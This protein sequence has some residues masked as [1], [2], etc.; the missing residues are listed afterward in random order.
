[1]SVPTPP[2]PG[3]EQVV[4]AAQVPSIDRGL[5]R[6]GGEERDVRRQVQEVLR[7]EPTRQRTRRTFVRPDRDPA[8]GRVRPLRERRREK[9]GVV[10]EPEVVRRLAGPDVTAPSIEER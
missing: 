2:Q 1:G 6:D 7:R 8:P 3:E 5:G 4:R 10:Q 9:A